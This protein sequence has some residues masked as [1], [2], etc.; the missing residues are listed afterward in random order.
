MLRDLLARTSPMPVEEAQDGRALEPDR[1]YVIR[2]N[3][4]LAVDNGVLKVTPRTDLRGHHM[5]IDSF[6]RALARDQ[7]SAAIGIVLSGT[8]SDGAQGL[9][10]IKAEGGITFAQD[11]KSA[12]YGGM[13]HAAVTAGGVDFVLPPDQIARELARIGGDPGVLVDDRPV[14]PDEE[15]EVLARI[16]AILRQATGIDLSYYKRPNLLR[17][18]H[19]RCLLQQVDGLAEYLRYLRDHPA[20][21][22]ALHHDILINVTSFFRDDMALEGLAQHVFPAILRDRPAD[23]PIRIWVP[24]CATGEE[25]YTFAIQL[26]EYLEQRSLNVPI[27]IFAT[28]VSDRAIESARAGAYLET[29]SAD[30]SAERLRR[31]FTKV[32]RG[33]QVSKRVRDLCVFAKH[34]LV[35][36]PPFSQLDLVSCCNVLIY[37]RQEYQRRV[38]ELFHYAL[39]PD[40]FLKLGRSETI[41]ASPDLFVLVDRTHKIYAKKLTS[42]RT[43]PAFNARTP[44]AVARGEP[45]APARTTGTWGLKDLEQAADRLVMAKYAPAGVLVNEDMTIVQFRGRTAP[46]IEPPPGDATLNLLKMA[47]HDL[48]LELRTALHQARRDH[49]AV[50]K[51]GLTTDHGGRRRT[52]S[53]EVIPVDAPTRANR[54]FLVLFEY[55]PLPADTPRRSRGST[56]RSSAQARAE[57]R[58]LASLRAE[59][60]TTKGHLKS[61]I[62]ELEA[63]NEEL[64]SANEETLSSN[65]E[66]QSTNEELETAK[67]ELQSINE[68]LTTVNEQLQ[69][70][71][72]ELSQTA[73]D[74]NNLLSSVNLPIVMVSSD[75]RIR[76]ATPAATRV[77][78]LLPADVGRPITDLNLDLGVPDLRSMLVEVIDAVAVRQFDVRDRSGR[79]YVLRAQPYRTQENK[80]DGAVMVLVDVDELKHSV[81]VA[82]AARETLRHLHEITDVALT[83]LPLEALLNELLQRIRNALDVDTASILLLDL[84]GSGRNHVLRA[85]AAIGL[86]EEVRRGI[87]VPFGQGFAGTIAASQKPLMLEE[88]DYGRVVSPWIRAKGI[89][90]LA[91]VPIEADGRLLGVLHVGSLRRRRFEDDAMHL[92]HLAGG[93]IARAIE[94]TTARETERRGR[95]TA[96]EANRAKD[97]FLAVLSHELRTPLNAMVSWLAALKRQ[98]DAPEQ[99]ARAAASLERSVWQQ[100]RL[101]RDLLDVSRIVAGKLDL[102]IEPVDVGEIVRLSVD[103]QRPAAERKGI[104][105]TS[106]EIGGPCR[107]QGDPARLGQAV[108]N[109]LSN[110]VK[111]TPKDGRIDVTIERL[112]QEV[113]ITVSDT[114]EGIAAEFLPH[115]FDRFRQSDNSTTRHHGGLGLGLAIAKHLAERHGGSIEAASPGRGQGATFVLSLPLA[116]EPGVLEA[117]LPPGLDRP[118]AS[119]DVSVLLVDDDADTCEGMAV[120]LRQSGA[121]V[122]I[123]RSVIRGARDRRDAAHRRAR[124]RHQHARQRRLRADR[125]DP[126]TRPGTGH[127]NVRHRDDRD[128][129]TGRPRARA[130]RRLRRAPGEADRAH[131][132]HR[133]V[134]QADGRGLSPQ[135]LRAGARPRR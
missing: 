50:R 77:L 97:D 12:K 104:V 8:A 72:A 135:P 131:R 114:G 80:I 64:K 47:R 105:L 57:R 81:E 19:R 85:R 61:I 51:D 1:L 15:D 31:F 90:S 79:R 29:I 109:L 127:E 110:A 74:L 119:L 103:E 11:E 107:V 10:A 27:Q 39:R 87:S 94:R 65:E 78:N 40:G 111:F 9:A 45:T 46:F 20:E 60:A 108:G 44:R 133:H 128:G 122:R 13:P 42:T 17:R 89:K 95:E 126:G 92:L 48:V 86:E 84:D 93:R 43:P 116:G 55:A 63:A 16:L 115:V 117:P 112:R 30:V 102:E 23:L 54:H 120:V 62:E 7:G 129:G 132:P 18:I 24:G 6:F 98:I 88:V 36:D 37:L 58:E 25:P 26:L 96:E 106:N 121:L 38:I 32:D 22:T 125:Q 5:P 34:N 118:Q 28:D 91:G 113:R 59:L 73:N 33:Y 82:E 4:D 14:A 76:R 52:F 83:D 71:N 101:V 41:G 3:T 70:R 49:R 100:A 67:E 68:E 124:Q 75:L 56:S 123:A 2:P 35:T 130:R 69:I 53:L 21:V 134:A 99:V 66:L